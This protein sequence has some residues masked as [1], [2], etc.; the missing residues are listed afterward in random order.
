MAKLQADFAAMDTDGNG[1]VTKEDLRKKAKEINYSLSEEELDSTIASMDSD[2]DGK[3][4]LEE[5]IA[6]AVR[7]ELNPVYVV[8]EK[9]RDGLPSYYVSN[10]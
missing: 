6:A 7:I 3:I 8:V 9:P 4:N 1:V 10:R 5:F 2:N